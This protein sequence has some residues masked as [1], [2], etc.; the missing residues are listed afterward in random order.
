MF[1][2][3]TVEVYIKKTKNDLTKFCGIIPYI[4]E[5]KPHKFLPIS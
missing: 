1:F 4:L 3:L 5:S 2:V